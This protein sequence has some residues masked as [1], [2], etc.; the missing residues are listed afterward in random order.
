MPF[1]LSANNGTCTPFSDVADDG[2][3]WV[4]LIDG[5]VEFSLKFNATWELRCRLR[6]GGPCVL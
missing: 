6:I 5:E 4:K 3:P 2:W 1:L